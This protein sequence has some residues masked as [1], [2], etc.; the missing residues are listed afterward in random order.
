MKIGIFS[1]CVVYNPPFPAGVARFFREITT[2]L[3]RRGHEVLL[4]EPRGHSNQPKIEEIKDGITIY[5]GFSIALQKYMNFPVCIPIKE[6]ITSI[7]FSLDV[8]HANNSGIGVLAAIISRRQRIPRVISYH[9]PLI[10]YTSY[11]PLPL[12]FLRSTRLVNR[13]ESLVY[14]IFNLTIVPTQGVKNEL[15]RRGFNGPFGFFP[16]CLD[17]QSLPKPS[18]QECDVFRQKYALSG[19]KVILFVGR[20]SPEKKIEDV[21]QLIPDVVK[22]EPLAHFL[23]VGTGPFLEDYKNL[24]R[25]WQLAQNVTFTGYLSDF[26]LFTA[27]HVSDVGLIFADDAQIFDMTILEYWSSG[28]PLIIR[29]AMGIEEVVKKGTGLLFADWS[30]AINHILTLLQD[31]AL[32]D[33]MGKN[34]RKMV[35][36]RYDIRKT[37]VQLEKLYESR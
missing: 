9:T 11:A 6:M 24:V 13:L 20:M 4:F 19:K 32:R 18:S 26:D 34:C 31:D 1:E 28:L 33:E 5:R 8:V 25:K 12:F 2:E 17:L 35:E 37:I 27:M 23:M 7:P 3:A 22:K 15:Q 21:L 10:H 36:Q 14:N 16:T 30:E 29:K